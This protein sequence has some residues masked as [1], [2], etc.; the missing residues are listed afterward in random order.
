MPTVPRRFLWKSDNG[1]YSEANAK[2]VEDA[3]S[4]SATIDNLATDT[5]YTVRV[6]TQVPVVLNHHR[7]LTA[8][9]PKARAR[10]AALP[11]RR[12][13]SRRRQMTKP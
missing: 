12:A 2:T 4:K 1:D 13:A 6:I 7:L 10:P 11:A 8:R 5:E 9:W 3:T